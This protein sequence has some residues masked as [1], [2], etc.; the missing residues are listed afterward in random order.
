M[1]ADGRLHG[2]S[3][4]VNDGVTDNNHWNQSENRGQAKTYHD[5]LEKALHE[6]G[7]THG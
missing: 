1:G 7:Q 5:D 4:F 2:R 6:G 3:R